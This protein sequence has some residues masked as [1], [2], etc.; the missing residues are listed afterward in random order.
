MTYYKASEMPLDNVHDAS[1]CAG[2]V[3][4]IH[5]PTEHHMSSWPLVWRSDKAAFERVCPHGVGHYDP[6]QGD[7]WA[8]SDQGWQWVHGCCGCCVR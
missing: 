5:S 4:V 2:R 6:D 3:C 7:W 1:L 8:E